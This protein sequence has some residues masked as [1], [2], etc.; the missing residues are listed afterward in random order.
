MASTFFGLN[1]AYS[2][3]QASQT[4]VNVTANNISNV[5]T[6]GYTRREVEQS[7]ATPLKVSQSYGMAGSGV[8]VDNINQIRNEYYD[9]QFFKA[10]T[11]FSEYEIK[12]NYINQIEDCFFKSD[13][14]SDFNTIFNN[15][16]NI[17]SNLES[18]AENDNLKAQFIS[19]A[20]NLC[21]YFNAQN[22]N[23]ENLQKS[24]NDEIKITID[25]I[26]SYAKQISTLNKQIN[27]IE[28]NG[29][30]ANELRDKRNLLLDDLSKLVDIDILETPIYNGNNKSN[31]NNFEVRIAGGQSLVNG[32]EFNKLE[33]VP[34]EYKVNQSD[35]DGLYDIKWENGNDFSLNNKKIGATLKGLIDLRDGNNEEYFNGTIKEV[36]N[37]NKN[38]YNLK[39]TNIPNYLKDV[40]K[41]SLPEKGKI[42]INGN[43]YDYKSWSFNK[44]TNE[45]DFN[46]ISDDNLENIKDKQVSIG[47]NIDYKGVPYY[48]NQMNEWVRSFSS[49]MNNIEKD[50]ENEYGNKDVLLFT[51]KDKITGNEFNLNEENINSSNDSYYKLTAK[52]FSIN[53]ILKEDIKN[54]GTNTSKNDGINASNTIKELSKVKNDKDNF[55]F[56]GCSA[57]EFLDCLTADISLSN[58][59]AKTFA[60]NYDNIRNSIE[61]NRLSVSGVDEDEEALNLVK[62]QESYNLSAK[63]MQ[64]LSEMYDRLILE[65]GV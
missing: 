1:I 65:T 53:K 7:A 37:I 58:N 62:Y 57:S 28:I 5:N 24:L 12:N 36:K 64:I 41:I 13:N 10:Q 35:A 32:Y 43:L 34:K 17:L 46:I 3:L 60:E 25:S 6:K 59:N 31:I 54:F 4:N 44:D 52:N 40:S 61:K 51:G 2:G 23:L 27:A 11:N 19:E 8:N 49:I 9:K 48:Q 39:I 55:N 42:K 63:V 22:A 15:M 56:R 26:D 38:E 16:F 21:E 33:C 20:E 29:N 30:K 50:A 45:F 47:D 14:A 18:N